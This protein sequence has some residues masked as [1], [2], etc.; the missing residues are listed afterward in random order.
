MYYRDSDHD[1]FGDPFHP[2]NS[3]GDVAPAGYVKNNYDCNDCEVGNQPG[4]VRVRMCHDGWT[5]CVYVKDTAEKR[6]LG[7]SLGLCPLQSCATDE[8]LMCHNGKQECVKTTDVASKLAEAGGKWSLGPYCS[9][10]PIS[11]PGSSRQGKNAM[12][13]TVKS[14][15]AKFS[16]SNQPNPFAG[17]STIKYELPIDSKVTIRVYDQAGRTVAV[18][19]NAN[20]K[21]GIY[22]V[23]FNAGKLSSGSLFYKIIARS[24]KGQYEQTNQMI[25]IK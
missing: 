16:L 10:V 22:T 7:W 1:G 6:R 20:K 14:T 13:G 17:T 19:V 4:L 15:P 3:C 23:D 18:L 5:Q 12:T 9:G 25:K 11:G 2:T 24:D 21:A 8:T